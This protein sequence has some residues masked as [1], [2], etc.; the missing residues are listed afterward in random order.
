MQ[1]KVLLRACTY[2]HWDWEHP[3]ELKYLI[4]SRETAFC[5]DFLHSICAGFAVGSK[6]FA[7]QSK[8]WNCATYT[9]VQQVSEKQAGILKKKIKKNNDTNK[10]T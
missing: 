8:E 1:S 10:K 7:R 4:L 6:S 9:N 5:I 3:K 2:N